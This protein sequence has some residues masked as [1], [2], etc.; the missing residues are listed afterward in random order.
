[1]SSARHDVGTYSFDSGK[2]YFLDTNIWLLVYGPA[3]PRDTRSRTYSDGFKRLRASGAAVLIDAVVV[4]ELV[5]A[6]TRFEFNQSGIRDFKAFRSSAPF[7]SIAADITTALRSILSFAKPIGTPF[8]NISLAPLLTSFEQG[9]R[10]F[11]DLLIVE[12]CRSRA[13]VLVTDDGDM[14][15]AN[16]PIVTGNRSLLSPA[17]E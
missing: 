11:N 8:A 7:R 15:D 4:S 9:G 17:A 6:W 12:T 3:R 1:L 5:N 14:R 10:D 13:C 2:Q 16:L